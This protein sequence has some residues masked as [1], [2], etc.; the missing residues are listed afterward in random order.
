MSLGYLVLASRVSGTER[1]RYLAYACWWSLPIAFVK[2]DMGY[3]CR[4]H[5]P[6]HLYPHRLVE[7]RC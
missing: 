4:S 6:H 5:R 2:E 7:H 3:Y 1:A